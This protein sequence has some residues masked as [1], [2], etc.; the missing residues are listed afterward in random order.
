MNDVSNHL[1]HCPP[2]LLLSRLF[3][4]GLRNL[5]RQNA[6]KLVEHSEFRLKMDKNASEKNLKKMSK[7]DAQAKAIS[8]YKEELYMKNVQLATEEYQKLREDMLDQFNKEDEY[9]RDM[10]TKAMTVG[11]SVSSRRDNDGRNLVII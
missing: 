5:I 3:V 8:D 2:S 7:K 10:L 6:I 4:F 1:A 9:A 11:S